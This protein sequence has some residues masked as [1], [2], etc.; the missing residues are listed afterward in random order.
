MHPEKRPLYIYIPYYSREEHED[1]NAGVFD[2]IDGKCDYHI[3]Q[4]K[5]KVGRIVKVDRWYD[6]P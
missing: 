2:V 5:G 3:L 4:D 1:E 6:A